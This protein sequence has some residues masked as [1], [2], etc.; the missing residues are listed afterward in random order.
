MRISDWS[1]GVC[2]SD[3]IH[4]DFSSEAKLE[5]AR[6]LAEFGIGYLEVTSPAA[7]RR[8]REDARAI[9][10]AGLPVTVAAHIR[11]HQDD[12]AIAID[13]GVDALHMVMA[14]SP[15]L[16]AAS[17]GK[18]IAEVVRIAADVAEFVRKRA[19]GVSLRDRKST[20]LTASH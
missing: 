5:I 10:S 19:P 11:C 15:I 2:S 4:A 9:A 7:S 17:H 20:R 3:L 14:T 13:T 6:A 8:S 1:S 18:A 12:A 16:R